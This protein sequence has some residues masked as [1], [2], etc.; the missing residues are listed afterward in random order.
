MSASITPTSKGSKIFYWRSNPID[1]IQLQLGLLEWCPLRTL[2]F[3]L[4]TTKTEEGRWQICCRNCIHPSHTAKLEDVL[5]Q[6]T[7]QQSFSIDFCLVDFG[8]SCNLF[9]N[10]CVFFS[11]YLIFSSAHMHTSI[12]LPVYTCMYKIYILVAKQLLNNLKRK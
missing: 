3:Q 6:Q 10:C 2:L 8:I 7:V 9:R 1:S 5:I 4:Q 12:C 11:C